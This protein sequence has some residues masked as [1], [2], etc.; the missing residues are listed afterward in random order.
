MEKF[1]YY[2][3]IIFVLSCYL[4]C[5]Y[6][7]GTIVLSGLSVSFRLP[8][9]LGLLVSEPIMYPAKSPV[10]PLA[11]KNLAFKTHCAILDNSPPLG[12]RKV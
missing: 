4:A 11:K 10:K 8:F 1:S 6:V 9:G 5:C 3:R 12:D 7:I 2:L